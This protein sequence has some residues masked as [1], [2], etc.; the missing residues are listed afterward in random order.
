MQKSR[1]SIGRLI[2]AKKAIEISIFA[3]QFVHCFIQWNL[4]VRQ[5]NCKKRENLID[6]CAQ[7]ISSEDTSPASAQ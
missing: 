4:H 3:Q 6:L 5:L 7:K 1:P 2:I